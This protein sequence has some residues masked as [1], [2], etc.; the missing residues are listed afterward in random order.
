MFPCGVSFCGKTWDSVFDELKYFVP[1]DRL[2]TSRTCHSKS[3]NQPFTTWWKSQ[4][5]KLKNGHASPNDFLNN[6]QSQLQCNINSRYHEPTV[7]LCDFIK[8]LCSSRSV[9]D[10]CALSLFFH[11]LLNTFQ[12][13]VISHLLPTQVQFT[14][15]SVNLHKIHARIGE[16][17]LEQSAHELERLTSA[18]ARALSLGLY[19]HEGISPRHLSLCWTRLAYRLS[20]QFVIQCHSEVPE[21]FLTALRFLLILEV[22]DMDTWRCAALCLPRPVYF[23][24]TGL[25]CTSTQ[26]TH[27]TAPSSGS[28]VPENPGTT[29]LNRFLLELENLVELASRLDA[30][31]TVTTKDGGSL[32]KLACILFDR[33]ACLT[34]FAT[35]AAHK[36]HP[37]LWNT[38]YEETQAKSVELWC[39]FWLETDN[40]CLCN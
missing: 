3:D 12:P 31:G 39:A 33:L 11:L 15:C 28:I 2:N 1:L 37:T 5:M 35:G 26:R 32:S 13:N 34:F 14:L 30:F 18:C 19:N 36:T 20:T 25:L 8:D 27:Q 24:L 6:I 9:P 7:S 16:L 22:T 10:D 40:Y 29:L 38:L 23:A 17:S 21:I 4:C